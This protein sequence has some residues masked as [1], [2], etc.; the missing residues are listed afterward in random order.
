MKDNIGK[1][2]KNAKV[3]L[4]IKGKTYVAKTNSNGKATFKIKKLTKNG[5]FTATV[6]FKGNIYFNAVTKNV[7]I[8]CSK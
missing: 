6:T 5:K 1:F 3:T 4:K 8:T 2:I 7:K